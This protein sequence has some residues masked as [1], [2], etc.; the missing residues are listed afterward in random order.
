MRGCALVGKENKMKRAATLF[1]LVILLSGC[2]TYRFQKGQ[3]PFN[4]GYVVS[5][6]DYIMPEYTLG[7][8]NTVPDNIKLAK[9]RFRKRKN[10]VEHY[11][12]KMGYIENRFKMT[13]LDPCILFTKMI[14]G[15]FRFPFIAVSDYRYEHNPIYREKIKKKEQEQEVKEEARIQSLK[16]KL[17]IY[18]QNDLNRGSL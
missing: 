1:L 2:A 8:D 17:N 13:F 15:I 12:K 7:K 9:D 18:I 14:G 6:D 5:R 3:E 4:K 16:N 10:I 11:Y